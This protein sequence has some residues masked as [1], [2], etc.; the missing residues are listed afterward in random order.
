MQDA[1]KWMEDMV[2]TKIVMD[3][4]LLILCIQNKILTLTLIGILK[5]KAEEIKKKLISNFAATT[6]PC[7][8][9]FLRYESQYSGHFIFLV[10]AD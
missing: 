8:V 7:A 1:E 6:R 4:V 2:N 10:T 5:S 9:N 3:M